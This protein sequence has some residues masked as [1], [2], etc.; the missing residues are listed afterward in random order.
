MIY[1]WKENVTYSVAT[2]DST[3][4]GLFQTSSLSW[5]STFLSFRF[6]FQLYI[7]LNFTS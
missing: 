6:A 3:N 4:L 7:T 1:V 5:D 2:E